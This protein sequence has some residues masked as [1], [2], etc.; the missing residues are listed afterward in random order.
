MRGKVLTVEDRDDI[1]RGICENLSNREIA[2]RLGRNQSVISRE[3]TRNGGRDNYRVHAAQ[4]RYET[5][6]SRSK[7]RKLEQNKR[8]HDAVAEKLRDDFSP[9]QISGRLKEDYPD[10][11]GMHVSHETIYQALFLQARGELR[12]Q[13]KLAL[14][15]RSG[16]AG[17]AWVNPPPAGQDRR[18]GQH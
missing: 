9:E 4:E 6:K 18:H 2:I 12:T 16:A 13:L 3:I 1:L 15:D 10:D 11:L 7:G 17:T 5:L 14:R 8:L